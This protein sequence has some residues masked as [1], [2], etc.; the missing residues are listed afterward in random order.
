M[1]DIGWEALKVVPCLMWRSFVDG[2][3][4]GAEFKS[5]ELFGFAGKVTTFL[6][7][8]GHEI[9]TTSG[10]G[11]QFRSDGFI[12]LKRGLECSENRNVGHSNIR[13]A[14]VRSEV[15]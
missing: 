6:V 2:T 3:S 1:N 11:W 8:E 13:N 15:N 12:R 7:G 5:T 4:L 14:F 9:T 10:Q